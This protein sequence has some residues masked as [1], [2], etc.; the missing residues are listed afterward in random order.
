MTG[1][2]RLAVAGMASLLVALG[3][4]AGSASGGGETVEPAVVDF[5]YVNPLDYFPS[6]RL[7]DG[8]ADGV[9]E[10]DSEAVDWCGDH[11]DVCAGVV[12]RP[13]AAYIGL[14]RDHGKTIRMLR[15]TLELSHPSRLR[16][17]R[18][19]YGRDEL[20]SPRSIR[21]FVAAHFPD[22][23]DRVHVY[24]DIPAIS[25]VL[26]DVPTADE[27]LIRALRDEFGDKIRFRGGIA[28]PTWGVPLAGAG[29]AE[30]TAS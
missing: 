11:R 4:L 14:T 13:E 17:F 2:R 8:L 23:V 12:R 26:L 5:A 10:A 6:N 18:A 28:P 1:L 19:P 25:R 3:F 30:A 7:V 29:A 24:A 16:A 21:E 27:D 9:A 15:E 22:K 20:P